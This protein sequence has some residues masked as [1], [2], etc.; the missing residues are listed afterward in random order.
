MK[1][2]RNFSIIFFLALLA[3]LLAGVNIPGAFAQGPT[4]PP[5]QD[6]SQVGSTDGIMLM[7]VILCVIILL[8]VI[9]HKKKK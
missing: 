1:N 7:G 2:S 8:P 5:A 6:A 9:F 3:V 4:I